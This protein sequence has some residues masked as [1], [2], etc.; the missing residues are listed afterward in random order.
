MDELRT[1]RS[2]N[3]VEDGPVFKSPAKRTGPQGENSS[4]DFFHCL[5]MAAE[6][7]WFFILILDFH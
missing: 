7:V 6:N 2:I 1:R 3:R 5:K 4:T